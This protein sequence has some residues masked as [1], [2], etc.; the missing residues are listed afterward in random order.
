MSR[1][2]WTL[3]QAAQ[4]LAASRSTLR[5]RLDH[6][7]FPN[8]YQDPAGVWK[9]PLEDFLAAGFTPVQSVSNTSI[10]DLAQPKPELAHDLAQRL[11]HA[12][13]QLSIE[14]AQRIAAEQ[15][16]TAQRQ[17]AES[18]EL[19]LRLLE[20]PPSPT[21]PTSTTP[22]PTRHRWWQRT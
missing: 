10:T 1:P 18:L 8:A 11:Q 20:P 12:E 14:R 5:R 13:N 4:H 7:D 22:S 21:P 6:N 2:H 16:A 17:R 3:T 15:V 19:A 9:I